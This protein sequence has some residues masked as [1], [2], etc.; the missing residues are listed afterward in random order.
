MRQYP[1]ACKCLLNCSED[2]SRWDLFRIELQLFKTHFQQCLGLAC[3]DLRCS[4]KAHKSPCSAAAVGRGGGADSSIPEETAAIL[5]DFCEGRLQLDK[6]RLSALLAPS[7][8]AISLH[9]R[10][11][12]ALGERQLSVSSSAT[13]GDAALAGAISTAC[14]WG[15]LTL[16]GVH[17]PVALCH[18]SWEPCFQEWKQPH[19]CTKGSSGVSTTGGRRGAGWWLQH[20]WAQALP[21]SGS[22]CLPCGHSQ[23]LVN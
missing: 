4:G 22:W 5:G 8:P 11:C 1:W 10:A 12:D 6:S 17:Q 19:G 21:T 2:E 3:F 18:L 16:A 20:T 9:C 13:A 15:G 23:P 14:A 7:S